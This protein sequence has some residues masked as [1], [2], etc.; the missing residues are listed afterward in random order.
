[1]CSSDL[2]PSHDIDSLMAIQNKRVVETAFM[3]A[4]DSLN[5]CVNTLLEDY[6]RKRK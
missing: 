5:E 1:M 3:E 2:F 4:K 6:A